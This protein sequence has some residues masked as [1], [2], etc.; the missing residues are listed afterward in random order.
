MRK[1]RFFPSTHTEMIL[2]VSEQMDKDMRECHAKAFDK[3]K[4]CEQC[5]WND[6]KPYGVSMCGIGEIVDKI[7]S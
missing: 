6:V 3:G 1:M 4:D 2:Y 5:S 7:L